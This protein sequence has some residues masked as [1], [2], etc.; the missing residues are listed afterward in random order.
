MLFCKEHQL[1]YRVKGDLYIINEQR[2]AYRQFAE[3]NFKG[4]SVLDLGGHIG[5]FAWHMQNKGNAKSIV[6]VEPDPSN[7][8]VFEK[9][10]PD[11]KLLKGAVVDDPSLRQVPLYLGK[12]YSSTNS[13]EYFQGRRS[14]AVRALQWTKLLDM[15]KWAGI[16]CDIEGGEYLLNWGLVPK[17]VRA[18]AFEFHYMR[19]EWEA[20]Q[21]AIHKLLLKM[22]FTAIREP[23]WKPSWH[24]KACL[25]CYTR[26]V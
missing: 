2:L 14:T 13:L 15:R 16:K 26:E 17:H 4:R 6:S 5:A 19:P 7:I 23:N 1:Y 10:C 24:I 18:L 20:K 9:N 22:G 8:E 21:I 11:V 25:A 12:N 3:C